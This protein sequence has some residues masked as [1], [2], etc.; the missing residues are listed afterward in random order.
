MSRKP[1]PA[2]PTAAPGADQNVTDALGE[3]RFAIGAVNAFYLNGVLDAKSMADAVT[4][5]DANVA[6]LELL[7]FPE[8][9]AARAAARRAITALEKLAAPVI[10]PAAPALS[11]IDGGRA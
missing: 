11:V 2:R 4:C 8:G 6:T 5:I 7:L 3:I 9:S 10:T 1:T